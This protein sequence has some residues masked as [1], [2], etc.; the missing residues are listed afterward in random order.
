AVLLQ[1]AI[2]VLPATPRAQEQFQWLAAEITELG[3]EV[4]LWRSELAFVDHEKEL[5]RKFER[6]VE[7]VYREILRSLKRKRRDLPALSR[8]YQQ[9]LAFDHFQSKLG[10]QVREALLA[11]RGEKEG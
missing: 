6:E 2:W 3:G 8:Q 11:A 7:V 9:A 4:T 1:D 5:V 10:K